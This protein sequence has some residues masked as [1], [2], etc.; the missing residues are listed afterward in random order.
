M[1]LGFL[2]QTSK[3]WDGA[4]LCLKSVVNKESEMKAGEEL[5][6]S[7]INESRLD[8][9]S[10]IY[11]E[12]GDKQSV[13]KRIRE[14]SKDSGFVFMGMLPP[15]LKKFREN[16]EATIREYAIYYRSMLKATSGFPP[17]AIV[18]A[19]ENL[20]FHKIFIP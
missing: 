16:P 8:A 6:Q 2:L 17:V 5:L 12:P 9:D 15:D 13:F 19:A 3:S 20:D 14:E 1:A 18:L 7:L 11:F 4:G 10:K